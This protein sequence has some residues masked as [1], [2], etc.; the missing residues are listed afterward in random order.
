MPVQDDSSPAVK[1]VQSAVEPSSVAA[2]ASSTAAVVVLGEDL[3]FSRL[4]SSLK[5]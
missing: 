5:W 4:V 2:Q 1:P 3:T